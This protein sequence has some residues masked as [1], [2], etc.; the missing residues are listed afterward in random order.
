MHQACA[1]LALDIGA[2]GHVLA[3]QRSDIGVLE[4]GRHR[5]GQHGAPGDVVEVAHH[6]AVVRCCVELAR[7]GVELVGERRAFGSDRAVLDGGFQRGPDQRGVDDHLGDLLLDVADAS[8]AVG[9][10]DELRQPD[11][12]VCFLYESRQSAETLP[13]AQRMGEHCGVVRL[14]VEE[15]ALMGHEHVVEDHEAL[16]IVVLARHGKRP[17]VIV[18]GRVGGVDDLDAW[19]VH[20]H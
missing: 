18:A 11:Q 2:C 19:S 8:S 1:V 15:H 4:V 17:R 16:G 3:G 6:G 5:G 12:F 10:G 7:I 14:A 9:L 20:R 13:Q